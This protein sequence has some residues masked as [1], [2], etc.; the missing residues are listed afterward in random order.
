MNRTRQADLHPTAPRHRFPPRLPRLAGSLVARW[1]DR[2]LQRLAL[3]ELE[4]HL[5][6]D[7]GVSREQARQEASRPFWRPILSVHDVQSFDHDR[8]IPVKGKLR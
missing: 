5:L 6:A 3:A 2:Y 1:Y 4:E 7:I 8:M